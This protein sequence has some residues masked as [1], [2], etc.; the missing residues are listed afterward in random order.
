MEKNKIL[1]IIKRLSECLT[2][3]TFNNY[4]VETK[5]ISLLFSRAFSPIRVLNPQHNPFSDSSWSCYKTSGPLPATF[6][7]HIKSI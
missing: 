5:N 4:Y 1:Q 7:N 3:Y 6:L 2:L